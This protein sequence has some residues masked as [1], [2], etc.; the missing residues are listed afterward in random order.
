MLT[1]VAR[2]Q[3]QNH[4]GKFGE[5]LVVKNEKKPD[6][7]KTHLHNFDRRGERAQAPPGKI[8]QRG[9]EKKRLKRI[10]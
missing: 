10:K 9:G 5:N 6:C 1:S 2:G 4:S 8:S 3:Q 7:K